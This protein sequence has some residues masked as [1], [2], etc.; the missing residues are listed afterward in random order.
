MDETTE[1]KPEPDNGKLFQK[2]K[3]LDGK[4]EWKFNKHNWKSAFKMDWQ[5]I[6]M[7][8]ILMILAWSYNHDMQ[9][10]KDVIVAPCDY[11]ALNGIQVSKYAEKTQQSYG[12]YNATNFN[13]SMN[14]SFIE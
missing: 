13:S 4:T 7:I 6:S 14:L 1:Q 9:M 3:G 2:I 11:C 10:C 8:I 5:S 12:Y